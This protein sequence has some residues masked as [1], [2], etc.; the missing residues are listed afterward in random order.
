MQILALEGT[1]MVDGI[2]LFRR[3]RGLKIPLAA[4]YFCEF[5]LSV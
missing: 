1:M 5:L 3:L 4:E 2:I